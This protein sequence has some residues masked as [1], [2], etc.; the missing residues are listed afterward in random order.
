MENMIGAGALGSEALSDFYAAQEKDMRDKMDALANLPEGRSAPATQAEAQFAA[1]NP[2]PVEMKVEPPAAPKSDM[3]FPDNVPKAYDPQYVDDVYKMAQGNVRQKFDATI[4]MYKRNIENAVKYGDAK[5][6]NVPTGDYATFYAWRNG[7]IKVDENNARQVFPALMSVISDGEVRDDYDGSFFMSWRKLTDDRKHE[8][9]QGFTQTSSMTGGNPRIK[10]DVK[11]T[12][13]GFKMFFDTQEAG[14]VAMRNLANERLL[15]KDVGLK[16][17]EDYF[18]LSHE[19]QME[20]VRNVVPFYSDMTQLSNVVQGAFDRM[21]GR[22]IECES[23]DA[24][25]YLLKTVL[26]DGKVDG[27]PSWQRGVV[28]EYLASGEKRSAAGLAIWMK[29]HD[30]ELNAAHREYIKD[31]QER[32]ALERSMNPVGGAGASLGEHLAQGVGT[33]ELSVITNAE[34]AP[35]LAYKAGGKIAQEFVLKG[36]VIDDLVDADG[37]YSAQKAMAILNANKAAWPFVR[38]W[39]DGMHG[40]SPTSSSFSEV[41]S[42]DAKSATYG[43]MPLFGDQEGAFTMMMDYLYAGGDE[44]A[45]KAAM[46]AFSLIDNRM[47]AYASGKDAYK[48]YAGVLNSFDSGVVDFLTKATT[49]A[50]ESIGVLKDGAD[51]AAEWC[52]KHQGADEAEWKL[53]AK[54]L[55]EGMSAASAYRHFSDNTIPGAALEFYLNLKAMGKLF[56]VSKGVVGGGIYAVGKAGKGLEKAADVAMK[57]AGTSRAV[58]N[59]ALG[60][61]ELGA[62]VDRAVGGLAPLGKWLA[63]GGASPSQSKVLKQ[64]DD[65]RKTRIANFVESVKKGD[66]VASKICLDNIQKCDEIAAG[67]FKNFGAYQSVAEKVADFMA[68]IPGSAY[69]YDSAKK[70]YTGAYLMGA[71]DWD[72][73]TL[74]RNEYF[75]T[76]QG[77]IEAVMMAGVTHIAQGNRAVTKNAIKALRAEARALDAEVEKLASG[78][79]IP[80]GKDAAKGLTRNV[81]LQRAWESCR[82]AWV[83]NAKFMFTLEEAKAIT[84]NCK[85]VADMKAQDPDYKPTVWDFV[86]G[87]QGAAV[88]EALNV[89]GTTAFLGLAGGA[90][91]TIASGKGKIGPNAAQMERIAR[92][93]VTLATKE[94]AKKTGEKPAEEAVGKFLDEYTDADKATRSQ[95]R[96][97]V[98]AKFGE[99][100]ARLLEQAAFEVEKA[101]TA[102]GAKTKGVISIAREL[103]SA[104]DMTPESVR[105]SLSKLAA[106]GGVVLDMMPDGSLRVK[107]SKGAKVG[108][109][110]LDADRSVVVKVHDMKDLNK[111]K[112]EDGKVVY[113]QAWASEIIGKYRDGTLKGEFAEA[114]DKFLAKQMSDGQREKKLAKLAN[115]ENL[116]GLLDIADATLT[117]AGIYIP[118]DD[119]RFGKVLGGDDA[120]LVDGVLLLADAKDAAKTPSKGLDGIERMA[121]K[122]GIDVKTFMHE[123]LHAIVDMLPISK[124]KVAELSNAY[125]DKPW[126]EGIVD[127][128]LDAHMDRIASQ[129]AAKFRAMSERGVL[130]FL[131]DAARKVANAFGIKTKADTD[132]EAYGNRGAIKAFV[133]ML[134]ADGKTEVDKNG[135]VIDKAE[136]DKRIDKTKKGILGGSFSV[137]SKDEMTQKSLKALRLTAYR[138]GGFGVDDMDKVRV[139]LLAD[140]WMHGDCDIGRYPVGIFKG[141]DQ[142]R[143]GTLARSIIVTS[144]NATNMAETDSGRAKMSTLFMNAGLNGLQARDFVIERKGKVVQGFKG[145]DPDTCIIWGQNGYVKLDEGARDALMLQ[146][147]SMQEANL[148]AWAKDADVWFDGI[149]KVA[150]ELGYKFDGELEGGLESRVWLD[151]KHGKVVKHLWNMDVSANGD[152]N[153]TLDRVVLFNSVFPEAAMKV[154]GWGEVDGKFG[155]FIE[156]PYVVGDAEVGDKEI[157]RFMKGRGFKRIEDPEFGGGLAYV[158]RDGSTVVRDLN[159]G[160]VFKNIDGSLEVIDA[161][162]ALNTKQNELDGVV[163]LESKGF[164]G[165][166]YRASWKIVENKPDESVLEQLRRVDPDFDEAVNPKNWETGKKAYFLGFHGTP[167]GG[168][169]KFDPKFSDDGLTLFAAQDWNVSRSYIRGVADEDVAYGYA[170][171]VDSLRPLSFRESIEK[172]RKDIKRRDDDA[173]FTFGRKIESTGEYALIDVIDR[174]ISQTKGSNKTFAE[175]ISELSEASGAGDILTRHIKFIEAE[176][177]LRDLDSLMFDAG[178]FSL[179]ATAEEIKASEKALENKESEK[180]AIKE[181]L[182]EL[183]GSEAEDEWNGTIGLLGDMDSMAFDILLN[184]AFINRDTAEALTEKYDRY[185]PSEIFR[186][187]DSWAG[188]GGQ[189]FPELKNLLHL[190]RNGWIPQARKGAAKKASVYTLCVKMDNPLVVDAGGRFWN[191]IPFSVDASAAQPHNETVIGNSVKDGRLYNNYLVKTRKLAEYANENG[192]DGVIVRDVIDYGSHVRGMRPSAICM[193]FDGSRIKFTDPITYD[194]NG[195]PNKLSDRFLFGHANGEVTEKQKDARWNVIGQRAFSELLGTEYGGVAAGIV[196]DEFRKAFDAIESDASRDARKR[197]MNDEINRYLESK[198]SN[199]ITITF[200]GQSIPV[201]FYRGGADSGVRYEYGGS[202][203]IIPRN[204]KKAVSE[205]SDDGSQPKTYLTVADFYKKDPLLSAVRKSNAGDYEVSVLNGVSD[206][207]VFVKGTEAWSAYA[208]WRRK[209]GHTKVEPVLVNGV[210]V[211]DYGDVVIDKMGDNRVISKKMNVAIVKLMQKYEGWESPLE[212]DASFY[213]KSD[214]NDAGENPDSFNFGINSQRLRNF[215]GQAVKDRLAEIER[216]TNDAD[217]SHFGRVYDYDELVKKVEDAIA[218]C[219]SGCVEYFNSEIEAKSV[220]ARF[221]ADVDALPSYSEMQKAVVNGL[222]K[223]N[224]K[225]GLTAAMNTRNV[226]KFYRDVVL[227]AVSALLP[228]DSHAWSAEKRGLQRAFMQSVNDCYRDIIANY[229]A[230]MGEIEE[231]AQ[232]REN[233]FAAKEYKAG[234][235]KG[236]NVEGIVAQQSDVVE[237]VMARLDSNKDNRALQKPVYAMMIDALRKGVEAGKGVQEILSSAELRKAAYDSIIEMMGRDNAADVD[238]PL[239]K[240]LL[241][242]ASVAALRDFRQEMTAKWSVASEAGGRGEYNQ[243]VRMLWAESAIKRSNAALRVERYDLKRELNDVKRTAQKELAAKDREIRDAKAEAEH[244]KYLADRKMAGMQNQVFEIKKESDEFREKYGEMAEERR[245]LAK[246]VANADANKAKRV[247]IRNAVGLSPAEVIEAFGGKDMV[248]ALVRAGA[249]G[250]GKAPVSAGKFANEMAVDFAITYR[251]RDAEFADMP[252]SEF[253]SNPI[254][255]AEFANTVASWLKYSARKCAYGRVRSAAERDAAALRRLLRPNFLTVKGILQE[256]VRKMVELRQKMEA[257][258]I[259]ENV[260]KT[261]D[262]RAKANKAIDEQVPEFKRKISPLHQEY[263]KQVGKCLDMKPEDV[264][265]EIAALTKEYEITDAELGWM[266]R[267]PATEGLKELTADQVRDRRIALLK[268]AALSRYGGMKYMTVGELGD[269]VDEISHDIETSRDRFSRLYG[270]RVEEDGKTVDAFVSE[271]ASARADKTG[272]ANVELGRSAKMWRGAL[273]YC[274]PDLFLRMKMFFKKGSAAYEMCEDFRRSMSLAHIEQT[275]I[276][277]AGNRQFVDAMREIYGGRDF[278]DILKDLMTPHAEWSKFSR[279]DWAVP[280][281]AEEVEISDG[282]GGTKKVKIAKMGADLNRTKGADGL[283]KAQ[284]MY[285]YAACTQGDMEINNRIYGRDAAYFEEIADIIGVEGIAVVKWMRQQFEMQ[286]KAMS[287]ICESVTGMPIVAP[288]ADYFPLRFE[289]D[290]RDPMDAR[291]RYEPDLFPS[292]LKSRENHGASRLDDRADV[293]HV[294]N[295]RL[296]GAAHY[297]AFAEII[298]RVRTTFGDSRVQTAYAKTIGTEAYREMYTQM[299]T[300]LNGGIPDQIKWLS[301]L[302]NF[303]TASTLFYNIPSAIKQFEGIGGW[304]AEMGIGHWLK[305]LGRF[306]RDTRDAR[307]AAADIDQVIETRKNEGFS[308]VARALKDSVDA[309]EKGNGR[310]YNI[311]QSYKKHGLTLTTFIDTLASR[312][313][314]GSYYSQKFAYYRSLGDSEETAKRKAIADVDY[315]IQTTQQ[316]SRPEFMLGVQRGDGRSGEFGKLFAQFAGPSYVRLGMELEALHRYIITS[317]KSGATKEQVRDARRSFINKAVALHVI[318]PAILTAL[319]MLGKAITH[320]KDDEDF[321]RDS[322]MSFARNVLTGPFAGMFLLGS[323]IERG[324]GMFTD[325]LFG[326]S[327][328]GGVT[329]PTVPMLSRMWNLVSKTSK[330]FDALKESCMDELDAG[331]L[332]DATLKT[333]EVLFPPLKHGENIIRNVGEAVE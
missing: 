244:V 186:N 103:Y 179:D 209:H 15:E 122:K 140:N 125:G 222:I 266:A 215:V 218:S 57:V 28:S 313:L 135:D 7:D 124:E 75:A 275:R 156:Q 257:N 265:A 26:E 79:K 12:E 276:A 73:E 29:D 134:T 176:K 119:P 85:A 117:N 113:D 262:R 236:E 289:Q 5:V 282:K 318:C 229:V 183:R 225:N 51:Y 111:H 115:G 193:T 127:D 46:E 277:D 283:S 237:K 251:D 171:F 252:I 294:F 300:A 41:S 280:S 6:G 4:S 323:Y 86:S 66:G 158:S 243:I 305:N 180:R 235:L 168:F 68:K 35:T 319:E 238:E 281:D 304:S 301:E 324:A 151:A 81:I 226:V 329:M 299:A 173:S 159:K 78:L 207:R 139:E 98:R 227:Q 32:A 155:A 288:V 14:D 109:F 240:K 104:Q 211:N 182:K 208:A 106:D 89:A 108:G 44:K 167:Q 96:D 172:W 136:R 177:E 286:R 60:V 50:G 110:T 152:I 91:R 10:W 67:M 321:V 161:I 45:C 105:A 19:R 169:T 284:L 126:Q 102:F 101:R 114:L 330:A 309:I 192:Y 317:E 249:V 30:K 27:L 332:L 74:Q 217:A 326:N 145:Y 63:V 147:R 24:G 1:Q 230:S 17:G 162:C 242:D 129:R 80:A 194:N 312:S 328:K 170:E 292:F 184:S 61:G 31:S 273:Y 261:L 56:D 307:D 40:T 3:V 53:K 200:E 120:S 259:V 189:E 18:S 258:T 99:D 100:A 34:G 223:P 311:Y 253:F 33:D 216:G 269:K 77:V 107:L 23:D 316:S 245:R 132:L 11:A 142:K 325:A 21:Q 204:F 274:V 38:R 191:Q 285:I 20:I 13:D 72:L 185:E 247:R 303:T 221:G 9:T 278:D 219:V 144:L 146:A 97:S 306:M 224:N 116:E 88:T 302:R 256:N 196:R 133:K 121:T 157:D 322:A 70:Q 76:A 308:D 54:H 163:P 84:D 138:E 141:F 178:G 202:S 87:G 220:G 198:K 94:V 210:G 153:R 239:A 95:M 205:V 331:E 287:P 231:A 320:N 293:F 315:A 90:S 42:R 213:R 214:L 160:G 123:Y 264:A 327:S 190:L 187:A 165:G 55:Y 52:A 118:K 197:V 64:L 82:K 270:E 181:R 149:D 150:K 83:D 22:D 268:V 62:K 298:D 295:E 39:V 137:V 69:F 228:K 279:R 232:I 246:R 310:M 314:A 234:G 248:D 131:A 195:N 148:R 272:A 128:F 37:R 263:W 250:D 333:F 92:S 241:L 48:S 254:V 47:G 267:G 175:Y 58:E 143:D 93:R 233:L 25:K 290:V 36:K 71:D 154:V 43:L 130:D 206:A 188:A 203:A 199:E 65:M 2:E 164:K 112:A 16:K 201:C 212:A 296:H 8:L 260:R 271:L 255:A 59:V 166:T 174:F 49:W 297:I 291:R